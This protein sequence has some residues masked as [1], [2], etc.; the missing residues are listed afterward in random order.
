MPF[1]TDALY[2]RRL[3]LQV[4]SIVFDDAEAF[5]GV[6]LGDARALRVSFKVR[7]AV[8][9]KATAS[10]S[11]S[12][13]DMELKVYNLA[14]R[15]RRNLDELVSTKARGV[16]ID[17][18]YGEDVGT[19]FRGEVTRAY[20]VRE[21]TEWATT[22]IAK[23]GRTLGQTVLNETVPPGATKVDRVLRMLEAAQRD[24]PGV[25]FTRALDRFKQRDMAGALDELGR[26]VTL[27]GR[28]FDQYR[29]L[30]QD[31]GLETWVEDEEVVALMADEVRGDRRVVLTP[32]TGLVGAPTP[33]F[34][35]KN[36]KKV[37]IRAVSRL[38]WRLGLGGV[39]EVSSQSRAGFFRVRALV[40]TGDT[41]GSEWTTEVEA[42]EVPAAYDPILR[43][44]LESELDDVAVGAS[45]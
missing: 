9:K 24:N 42:V 1:P 10:P 38:Q 32:R 29:V 8:P 20:S 28:A 45:A 22:I 11:A 4:G 39:V 31:L 15:T 33:V 40:H 43:R 44:T 30:A 23:A 34:D 27:S 2:G 3:R 35:E 19:V 21:G 17:A 6:P 36:P 5:D 16:A 14:E 7:K 18:G 25:S 26:G 41:H 37:I 12:S 13:P